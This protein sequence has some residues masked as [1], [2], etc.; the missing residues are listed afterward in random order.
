[1]EILATGSYSGM[2]APTRAWPASTNSK[3]QQQ[4]RNLSPVSGSQTS[5][6]NINLTTF[7]MVSDEPLLLLGNNSIFLLRASN[8]SLKSIRD[9]ILANFLK[10]TASS[11]DGSLIHE[12]LEV[13][14]SETRGPSSNFIKINIFRQSLSSGVDLFDKKKRLVSSRIHTFKMKSGYWEKSN[15]FFK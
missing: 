15:F 5:G 3:V 2:R 7:T 8:D 14:T 6:Y 11:K 4:I 13:S 12:V 1:M 9:L 10:I